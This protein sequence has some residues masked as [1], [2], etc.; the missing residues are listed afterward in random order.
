MKVGLCLLPYLSGS[1][2][3]RLL[4]PHLGLAT[5]SAYLR[6]RH[7]DVTVLDLRGA[8]ARTSTDHLSLMTSENRF[9][10]ETP[11]LELL[12]PLLE[13][14]VAGC[15]V[16]EL[17]AIDTDPRACR[18]YADDRQINRHALVRSLEEIHAVVG[19]SLSRLAEFDVLGFSTY[20]SN[21]YAV[22]LACAALKSLRPFQTIIL[23]GPEVTQGDHTAQLLLRAGLVD[24]VIPGQAL[25]ATAE[26]VDA[27]RNKKPLS[28][29]PGVLVRDGEANPFRTSPEVPVPMDDLPYPDYSDFGGDSYLP[30]FYP[31][32]A[33]CGCPFHCTF[34]AERELFGGYRRMSVETALRHL[35]HLARTRRCGHV[36]FDDSLLNADESWLAG[37]ADG[38]AER[39]IDVGWGGYLRVGSSGSL[40]QRMKRA[41]FRRGIIGIESVSDQLLATMNKAQ[42]SRTNLGTVSAFMAEGL[43]ATLTMIV[44]FPGETERDHHELIELLQRLSRH[45]EELERTVRAAYRTLGFRAL[46]SAVVP[47]IAAFSLPYLLK[48]MSAIYAS[49]NETGLRVTPYGDRFAASALPDPVKQLI[50]RIPRTFESDGPSTREVYQRAC[51][52][53]E[54]P[55]IDGRLGSF[56]QYVHMYFHGFSDADRFTTRHLPV[57]TSPAAAGD[58]GLRYRSSAMDMEIACEKVA[59]AAVER[60]RAGATLAELRRS[61]TPGSRS[62]EVELK[63]LLAVA[64][65]EE[66][67]QVTLGH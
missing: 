23:G 28:G 33:S 24:A 47:D 63:H 44:G 60:L 30:F 35:E 26:V 54:V 34:C 20:M 13:R 12:V 36:H 4:V 9:V 7:D 46:P 25:T 49:P 51:R 52:A 43:S 45:N 39:G 10:S 57:F 16:D 32:V 27:R 53:R 29:I 58:G 15:A 18:R 65:V 67:L 22:C 3:G 61:C 11:T 56:V 31:V 14:F 17:L 40:L 48:P 37:L 62:A 64:S 1:T 66:S 50:S 19:G 21:T 6:R 8:V 55:K 42:A 38:M 5:L 41:G 59:G 2:T